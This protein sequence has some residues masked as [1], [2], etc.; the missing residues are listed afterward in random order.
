VSDK[1]YGVFQLE[2]GIVGPKGE[3]SKQ[4]SVTGTH[5]RVTDVK[6][7]FANVTLIDGRKVKIRKVD[8]RLCIKGKKALAVC[9]NC[10]L[11]VLPEEGDMVVVTEDRWVLFVD[12]STLHRLIVD[13]RDS[14][15]VLRSTPHRGR[16]S[17]TSLNTFL[18]VLIEQDLIS[19]AQLEEF[20]ALKAKDE[21]PSNIRKALVE[22]GYQL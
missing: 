18:A 14:R 15:I 16:H 9:E 13:E 10:L 5:G 3:Y 21:L 1:G 12:F 20:R 19:D 11:G 6:G 7:A 22:N 2:I 4:G 17:A 8:G